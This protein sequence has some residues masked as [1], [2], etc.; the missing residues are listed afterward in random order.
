M[1]ES[2][3]TQAVRGWLEVM[4][5]GENLC[6]F[7]ARPM[8][9]GLVRLAECKADDADGIYRCVLAEIDRLLNAP[10]EQLETTVVI[11]AQGLEVFED[12]LDMLAALQDA[13]EQLH[14]D[15]VLQIASF[16]PDYVFEG[17][18]DDDVTNYTNRS[19]YPLFH[20]IREESLT[21]ALKHVPEPEKIP[22]RNQQRMR[23][24]GRSGIEQLLRRAIPRRQD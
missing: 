5:V 22:I 1:S 17:T 21:K 19:P 8:N 3:I 10:A 18:T 14:L 24:L 15:G 11:V 20:L 4:V 23:E 9:Q 12:Y 6:P 13:L 7:A 16:H 2:A